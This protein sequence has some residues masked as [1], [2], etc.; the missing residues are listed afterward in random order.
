MKNR[1][2]WKM[3]EGYSS[4]VKHCSPDTKFLYSIINGEAKDVLYIYIYIY[5]FFFFLDVLVCSGITEYFC[6]L[7][8][9]LKS[10]EGESN[11]NNK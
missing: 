9:I 2:L 1:E 6:K 7:C 3:N 11:M 10:L 4:V 8:H 5:I